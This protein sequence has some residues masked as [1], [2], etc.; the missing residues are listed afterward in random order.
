[1]SDA[2]W[3]NYGNH[4]FDGSAN[5]IIVMGKITNVPN[6]WGGQQPSQTNLKEICPECAVV[7]GVSDE[8]V[9]PEPPAKRKKEITD[10]L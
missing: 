6:Q 2:R 4:A 3:C 9:A 7:L 5:G 10:K 8:Y 1:M